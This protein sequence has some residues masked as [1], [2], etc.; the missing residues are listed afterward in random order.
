MVSITNELNWSESK[1][2][3]GLIKPLLAINP[4]LKIIQPI[5]SSLNTCEQKMKEIVNKNEKLKNKDR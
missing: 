3:Q 1:K 2:E 5:I 4:P